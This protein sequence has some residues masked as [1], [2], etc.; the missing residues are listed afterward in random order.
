VF[1]V[2]V[3]DRPIGL[4]PKR[5]ATDKKS[6]GKKKKNEKEKEKVQNGEI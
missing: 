5:Y 2:A 3:S 1:T 4:Y 6:P